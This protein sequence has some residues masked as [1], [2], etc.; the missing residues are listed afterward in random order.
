MS[1]NRNITPFLAVVT[2]LATQLGG[3]IW[4][5][6]SSFTSTKTGASPAALES[7]KKR[8]NSGDADQP[9]PRSSNSRTERTA[10][11]GVRTDGTNRNRTPK[12]PH[13]EICA[14]HEFT[15][16]QSLNAATAIRIHNLLRETKA[17]SNFEGNAICLE[18]ETAHSVRAYF[19]EVLEQHPTMNALVRL[20]A[21][22]LRPHAPPLV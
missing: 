9:L 18:P 13:A 5:R 12:A 19:Q 7:H 20:A 14:A 3:A 1:R 16:V 21:S 17:N 2:L 6:D 10:N 22:N 8:S 4:S 15:V 11:H